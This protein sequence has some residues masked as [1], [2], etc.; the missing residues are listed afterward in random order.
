MVSSVHRSEIEVVANDSEAQRKLDA[1]I[2]KLEQARDLAASIRVGGAGGAGAPGGG[3][4]PGGSGG[5]G[6]G[7]S[8]TADGSGGSGSGGGSA[9]KPDMGADQK[10][11]E[12]ETRDRES[13]DKAAAREQ[14]R[15]DAESHSARVRA[16][17]TAQ[18]AVGSVTS[19]FTGAGPAAP[20]QAGAGLLRTASSAVSDKFPAVGA[21]LGIGA[22]LAAPVIAGANEHY[23]LIQ[24]AA[25]LE[26][27]RTQARQAGLDLGLN[28]N[29]IK[30][31]ANIYGIDPT[32]A[33]NTL[34]G[35]ARGIGSTNANDA[36]DPFHLGLLGVDT[37]AAARFQATGTRGGG[38]GVGVG[39]VAST[40]RAIYATGRN[41]F[42]FSGQKLDDVVGRIAN[43]VTGMAER[44]LSLNPEAVLSLTSSLDAT[45]NSLGG[46]QAVAAAGRLSSMGA[47]ASGSF[48]GQFAG[49]SSAAVLS[50][51]ARQG[52]SL[53]DIMQRMQQM[54]GRDIIRAHKS[55]GVEGGSLA[56]ASNG[57]SMEQ[58]R[59]LATG[60]IAPD[61][62]TRQL[63]AAD[64]SDLEL[65]KTQA[66]E[67]R[68]LLKDAVINR[69]EAKALIQN[70]FAIKQALLK[71]A[72]MGGY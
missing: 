20:L 38:A 66:R 53:T 54:S 61:I 31:A 67:Q 57:F 51:A 22:I 30:E 2:A 43:A 63:P 34:A 27:P 33:T 3:G 37:S 35:Y 62:T 11:Q 5:G 70:V 9:P 50:D 59:A 68:N 60:D 39:A 23:G 36:V 52:G 17:N 32:E 64:T 7:A 46:T 14:Q 49:L 19:A 56:L 71:I 4:A 48:L 55:L 65:S 42:G 1:Y 8:S 12:K 26:R 58:A 44:G 69:E 28:S 10:R 47:D 72:Q 6:P 29:R 15:K 45:S 13:K 16:A 41:Q 40:L 24:E 25:G 18:S 21:A